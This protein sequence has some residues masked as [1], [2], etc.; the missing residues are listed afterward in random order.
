MADHP[1]G[2]SISDIY[3]VRAGPTGVPELPQGRKC[4]IVD[5]QNLFPSLDFQL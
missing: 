5:I 3:F 1:I 2:G 4:Q